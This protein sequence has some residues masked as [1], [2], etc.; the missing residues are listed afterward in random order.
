[1]THAATP[2]PAK[3]VAA[4]VVI[5]VLGH[6]EALRHCL[7][8]LARQQLPRDT[9]EVIVVENGPIAG[10]AERIA[11]LQAA[12][13]DF[14]ADR[15][16]HE[17]RSGPYAARNLGLAAAR[18]DIIAFT[19]ADCRPDADWLANGIGHLHAHPEAAAVAGAIH[20]FPISVLR[21]TGVELYELRHGFQQD[22]YVLLDGFG[23][24]ANL[25]VRRA[26]FDR[27]GPFDPSL[28]SGGDR[29][30]GVRLTA[31]GAT[32]AYEPAAIVRHPA[33]PTLRQLSRKI[34]RVTDGDITLR[35]RNGWSRRR[36]ARYCLG[37]LRPPVRTIWQA[38][39]DPVLRS[40]GE[41]LRYGLAFVTARWITV[42]CR[43]RRLSAWPRQ[44]ART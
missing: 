28:L 44:S 15:V 32:I 35:H 25:F 1:M 17:P 18:A 34:S 7:Q 13:A 6:R 41:V 26:A 27:V 8:A 37:P 21:R 43:L 11:D 36:Y 19:D 38:R 5:P 10:A 2:R 16:L 4:S 9:F 31:S 22:K 12:L 20:L 30:W 3:P 42:W 24:T 33:R 23:A 40:D 29:E 14:P 39:R